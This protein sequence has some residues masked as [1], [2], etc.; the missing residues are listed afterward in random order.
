MTELSPTAKPTSPSN[1]FPRTRL[2][3]RGSGTVAMSG[4][5]RL[6]QMPDVVHILTP[7]VVR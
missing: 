3:G 4:S 6:I 1:Q 5:Y 2:F 7:H